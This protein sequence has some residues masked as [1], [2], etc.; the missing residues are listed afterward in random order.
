M[1]NFYD[2]SALSQ[3]DATILVQLVWLII[4][5]KFYE[6]GHAI[7]LWKKLYGNNLKKVGYEVHKK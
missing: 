4:D 2:K 6:T 3:S 7:T 1:L 5:N